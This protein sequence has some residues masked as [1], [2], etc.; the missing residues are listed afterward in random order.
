MGAVVGPLPGN[1]YH[2]DCRRGSCVSL[3]VPS[4]P[5]ASTDLLVLELLG[6]ADHASSWVSSRRRRRAGLRPYYGTGWIG[7]KYSNKEEAPTAAPKYDPPPVY[8]PPTNQ[9]DYADNDESYGTS[10]RMNEMQSPLQS[11]Q[12]T[13]ARDDAY[14]PPN[15][16]PADR[17]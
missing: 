14:S 3:T 2:R 12:P 7:G 15:G 4:L 16:P 6:C 13:E 5:S 9:R 1:C 10:H 11:F 17:K 8:S